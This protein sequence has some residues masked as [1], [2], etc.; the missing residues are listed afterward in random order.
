M[1]VHPETGASAGMYAPASCITMLPP[2]KSGGI[3]RLPVCRRM[4]AL[5]PCMVYNKQIKT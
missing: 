1:Q 3:V 2:L 5:Y 4:V